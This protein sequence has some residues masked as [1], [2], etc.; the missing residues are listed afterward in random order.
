[1]H[2]DFLPFIAVSLFAAYKTMLLRQSCIRFVFLDGKGESIC[3]W[4]ADKEDYTSVAPFSFLALSCF[5]NC[6]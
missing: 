1:M 6:R 4:D 2:D 5:M 3:R